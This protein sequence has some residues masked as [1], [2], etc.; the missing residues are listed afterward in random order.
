MCGR[1]LL[2]PVASHADWLQPALLQVAADR[3]KQAELED[4][5]LA[6][7]SSASGSLLDNVE[8]INTLDDSKVTWQEVNESLKVGVGAWPGHLPW[9]LCRF[10]CIGLAGGRP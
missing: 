4:H 1:E 6:L 7:L 2:D 10:F 9:L 3:R 8:L 5:I